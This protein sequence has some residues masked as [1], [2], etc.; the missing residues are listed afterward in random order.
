MPGLSGLEVQSRLAN[1]QI[2]APVIVLTGHDAAKSRMDASSSGAH[3]YLCKPVD[4]E[5]LLDA[6]DAAVFR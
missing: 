1:A 6:I 5:A 3:G 2:D 4:E